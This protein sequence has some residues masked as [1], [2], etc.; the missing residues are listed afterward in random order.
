MVTDGVY[1]YY[2]VKTYPTKKQR[3]EAASKEEKR[4]K[5]VLEVY[6]P[7]DNF[8]FVRKV[9]LFH[10]KTGNDFFKSEKETDFFSYAQFACNGQYLMCFSRK[11]Q[12]KSKKEKKHDED[13][14]SYWDYGNNYRDPEIRFF[15]VKTGH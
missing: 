8:K 3:K 15:D 4:S 2:I 10:T 11:M 6:D 12:D 7:A 9:T 1:L 13:G 14:D 5:L